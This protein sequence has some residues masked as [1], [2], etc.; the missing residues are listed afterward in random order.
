MGVTLSL[1]HPAK[2]R[3]I[4]TE[5][6]PPKPQWSVDEIGD[7]SG[8]VALITGANTG[9]AKVYVAA[10]SEGKGKTAVE[11]INTKVSQSVGSRSGSATLLLLDLAD[12]QS[13]KSAADEFTSKETTLDILL[14]SGGV[15]MPPEDPKVMSG[16]DVQFAT[17]V[18]GHF[19][20]T[21][22]LLPTLVH[23]AQSTTDGT[24]RVVN[25][26]SSAQMGAPSSDPGGIRFDRLSAGSS[27]ERYGQSKLG[28][29]VF[30]NELARRYTDSGIVSVSLNPGNIQTELWQ[31]QRHSFFSPNT[32][33]SKYPVPMGALTQ[34]YLAGSPNVSKADSGAYYIPWARRAT[35]IRNEAN[36]PALGAKLWDWC[37]HEMKKAGVFE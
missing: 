23:T 33:I 31:H 20:L 15:M 12:L 37:E 7:L 35:P 22:L 28:N 21:R 2:L 27:F 5:S 26:A 14:N 3:L 6:F 17:N 36:D 1:L 13:V 25:V 18:L 24:A 10:R 9:I 16:L 30:S 11:R 29:I 4:Y 32:F 34:L 8:K 19:A